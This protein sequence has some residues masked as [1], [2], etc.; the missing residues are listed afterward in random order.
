MNTQE[1]KA[2]LASARQR[3]QQELSDLAEDIGGDM[4]VEI[5]ID[6]FS[7]GT[8]DDPNRKIPNIRLSARLG[9]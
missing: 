3:I 8:H 2:R 6:W 7:V 1:I 9:E 4:E 5:Q